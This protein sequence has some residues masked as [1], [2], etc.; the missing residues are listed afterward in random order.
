MTFATIVLIAVC[1]LV[2]LAN[3]FLRLD[4]NVPAIYTPAL[5]NKA[6]YPK[7]FVHAL[8]AYGATLGALAFGVPIVAAVVILAVSCIAWEFTQRGTVD[9]YDIGAGWLGIAVAVG[10]V[11]A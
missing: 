5:T 2:L 11:L 1:L 6:S 10:V 8:T 4:V 9:P 3:W 7:V